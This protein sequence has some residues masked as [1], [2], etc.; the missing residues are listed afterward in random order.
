[1][2][3]AIV[4]LDDTMVFSKTIDDDMFH[5]KALLALLKDDGLTLKLRKCFFL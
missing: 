3:F 1:M 5:L 4:Y 2:K